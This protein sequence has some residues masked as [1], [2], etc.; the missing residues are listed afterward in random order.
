[1]EPQHLRFGG[2]AAETMLHPLVA[3]WLLIAIV[4]MLTRPRQQALIVFL[5]S[6]FTIPV[7]QVVVLGSLH[8][9]VL[10]ILSF[11]RLG[12]EGLF[13]TLQLEASFPGDSTASTRWS[14]SGQCQRS[15]SFRFN[16]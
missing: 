5:V 6:C 11:G 16:G 8:F 9:T 15:S 4:L 12:S 7:G 14:C 1:M 2:G 3:V 13:A 10:R